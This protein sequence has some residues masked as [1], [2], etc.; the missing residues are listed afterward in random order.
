MT[1]DQKQ[2]LELTEQLLDTGCQVMCLTTKIMKL[3]RLT[4]HII[5][6]P[7]MPSSLR[8]YFSEELITLLMDEEAQ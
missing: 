5:A 4:E 1:D 8:T 6:H 7:E 2:I 3:T